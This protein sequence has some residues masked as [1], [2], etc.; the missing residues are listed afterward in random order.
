MTLS[1]GRREEKRKDIGILISE[2]C[3][4][5]AKR[6]ELSLVQKRALK[7]LTRAFRLSVVHGDVRF[8]DTNWYVTSGGLA[9]IA[10]RSRCAGI[11]VNAVPELCDLSR[12]RW[13]FK[14]TVYKTPV[15]RASSVMVT[16]I[17]PTHL[18]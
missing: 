17:L 14:A 1:R 5:A 13:V 2:N 6:W 3:R 12:D 10:G 15:R 16:P 11:E 18:L 9:R 4:Q 7:A 8:F